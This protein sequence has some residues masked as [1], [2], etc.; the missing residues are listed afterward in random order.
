VVPRRVALPVPPA[1]A[2]TGTGVLFA[3]PPVNEEE[4]VET[5]SLEPIEVTVNSADVQSA[6]PSGNGIEVEAVAV[7]R[8][9]ATTDD[10][11]ILEPEDHKVVG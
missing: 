8:D 5:T 3:E 11:E 9:S 7:A 2:D 4:T 10:T 1:R 6:A